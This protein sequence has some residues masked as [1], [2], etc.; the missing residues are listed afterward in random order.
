MPLRNPKCEPTFAPRMLRLCEPPARR[1]EFERV[2]ALAEAVLEALR[3]PG[4]H[5]LDA[6]GGRHFALAH[7]AVAR[8]KPAGMLELG[9]AAQLASVRGELV[10][11]GVQAL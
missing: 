5:G 2:S 11:Q 10:D 7:G 1:S 4:G 6:V 8:H 3:Q 9:G